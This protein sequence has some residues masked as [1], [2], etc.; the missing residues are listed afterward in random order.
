M[1]PIPRGMST[2]HL[3]SRVCQAVERPQ[4]P[5]Q[6]SAEHLRLTREITESLRENRSERLGELILRAASL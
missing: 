1:P 6:S 5:Y 3:P 4:I 2:Q